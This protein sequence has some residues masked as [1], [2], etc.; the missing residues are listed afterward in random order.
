M[1]VQQLQARSQ[2]QAHGEDST[3]EG[4]SRRHLLLTTLIG[5]NTALLVASN[6]AG[7]KL[8][9]LPFG[10]AASATVFSYALTFAFTDSISELFGK[11]AAK[12]AVRIGFAG[13]F[14]SVVFFYIAIWAP[15][16]EGWPGQ[17]AYA[18]TLGLSFRLLLGGCT[19]YLV[20]QH[21]DVWLFHRIKS[22]TGD[23]H[24]W[25]R[26]NGST[27]A[28]QFVDTC[29]FMSISFGGIF[30]LLPAILGQYF[31]KLVIALLDTPVVYMVVS[32]TRRSA[33]GRQ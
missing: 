14:L 12:L 4:F 2:E 22:V 25:L 20:S 23:R 33:R 27:L 16:A 10:L 24:L 13:L 26:N 9:E 19:S 18:Q 31:L 6:A 32:L 8:I 30:P 29:I 15:P 21:L 7:A 1:T 5:L 28:S 17:D 3:N 11:K